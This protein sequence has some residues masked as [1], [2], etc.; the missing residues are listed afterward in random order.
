MCKDWSRQVQPRLWKDLIINSHFIELLNMAPSPTATALAR[1]LGHIREVNFHRANQHQLRLLVE[2]LPEQLGGIVNEPSTVCTNLTRIDLHV[3]DFQL[4]DL[5]SK[6]LL[7]LLDYNPRLTYLNVFIDIFK[8]D[9]VTTALSKLRHLQHLTVQSDDQ[10]MDIPEP[11]LFLR[12]CLALPELTEL[13][14]VDEA[15]MHW[16][17]G[18]ETTIRRELEAIINEAAITRS[19]RGTNAKKIKQFTFPSNRG[20]RWNPLPLPLLKS[21]M[22]DLSTFHIPWFGPAA[23]IQ[24]IEQVIREHCPNVKHLVYPSHARDNWDGH[25]ARAVIRGCSGLQS[26][27]SLIFDDCPDGGLSSLQATE[28]LLGNRRLDF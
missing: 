20:G 12:S 21:N 24:E 17:D 27:T 3:V 28:T 18:D 22:L 6:P 15:E 8:I 23:N 13:H 5:M 26:F 19:S 16:D 1:N 10:T 2:G 9:G 25:S 14:F 4:I 11:L 7:T